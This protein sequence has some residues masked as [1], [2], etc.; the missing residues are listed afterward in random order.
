MVAAITSDELAAFEWER[1]RGREKERER[2]RKRGG[3]ERKTGVSKINK[4]GSRR[5]AQFLGP[6]A[7]PT[8]LSQMKTRACAKL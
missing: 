3:G 6:S 5:V 8:T 1:E 4:G 2:G 7:L